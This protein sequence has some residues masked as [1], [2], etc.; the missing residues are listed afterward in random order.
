MSIVYL[1]N[2]VRWLHLECSIQ[3][4]TAQALYTEGILKPPLISAHVFFKERAIQGLAANGVVVEQ[5]GGDVQAVEVS[6]LKRRNLVAL[7]E[8]IKA[9]AEKMQI[10]A[11][12]TGP[13]EAVVLECQTEHGLG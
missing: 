4:H 10:Y 12:P 5:L 8:A 11:D 2:T 1:P 9:Q 13:A 6:A 3:V 7:L